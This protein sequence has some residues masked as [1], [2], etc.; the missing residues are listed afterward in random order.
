MPCPRCGRLAF[1]FE[2]EVRGCWVIERL[3]CVHCGKV[4]HEWWLPRGVCDATTYSASD[5]VNWVI[6]VDP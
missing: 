4:V 6:E 5:A 2:E 1:R 3:R